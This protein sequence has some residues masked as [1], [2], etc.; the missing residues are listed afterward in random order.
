MIESIY[1]VYNQLVE[2][3][4]SIMIVVT[5]IPLVYAALKLIVKLIKAIFGKA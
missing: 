1:V 3:I 2:T 4:K 5:T